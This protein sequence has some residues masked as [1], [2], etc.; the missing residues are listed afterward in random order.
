MNLQGRFK[1]CKGQKNINTH[2]GEVKVRCASSFDKQLLAK[3]NKRSDIFRRRKKEKRK[4][5]SSDN[6]EK[7]TRRVRGDDS[8]EGKWRSLVSQKRVDCCNPSPQQLSRKRR[9]QHQGVYVTKI[10]LLAS[11]RRKKKQRRGLG[12]Q[13]R[14]SKP[15]GSS[16]PRSVRGEKGMFS[17]TQMKSETIGHQKK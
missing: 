3:K 10:F 6:G 17:S 2:Q 7:R 13:L 8:L 9:V 4:G 15:R 12:I 5:R 11:N 14:P 16:N 1:G